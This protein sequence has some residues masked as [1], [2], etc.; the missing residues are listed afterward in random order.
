MFITDLQ[1]KAIISRNYRGDVPLNKAI[2]QFSKYLVEVE[3][4]A[5]KPVFHVD[6]NGD[7]SVGE[8][9]GSNGAGGEH[10]VYVA[11]ST[12]STGYPLFSKLDHQRETLSRCANEPIL[13]SF[14][15]YHNHSLKHCLL[16]KFT[17]YKCISMCGYDK[18]LQRC[19]DFDIFVPT[20]TSV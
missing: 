6:I 4:E 19:F 1:G 11:V 12:E 10:F 16:F 3:D 5:K 15:Y 18:E 9:V 20:S 14:L 7:V 2:D 13:P 8:D 17:A